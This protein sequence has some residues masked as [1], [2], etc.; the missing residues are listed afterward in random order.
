MGRGKYDTC[1]NCH[2]A[3]ENRDGTYRCTLD[4][5][6]NEADNWCKHHES[7]DDEK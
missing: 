4:R 7:D 6:D 3:R 2:H 1:K 5:S